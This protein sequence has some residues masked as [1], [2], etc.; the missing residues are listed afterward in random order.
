MKKSS[1][2]N[3]E[4]FKKLCQLSFI[5]EV[6]LYGSRARQDNIARADIDLAI[7]CPRATELDWFEIIEIIENADTLLHIDCIRFD[8]LLPTNKLRQNIENDKVVLFDKKGIHHV[9]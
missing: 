7:I 2:T 4:F 3:Y 6:W 1:I 5:D 8:T 9:R